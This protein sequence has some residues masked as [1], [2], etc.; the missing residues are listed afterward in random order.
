MREK[1]KYCRGKKENLNENK[2]IRF[3]KKNTKMWWVKK[4]KEKSQYYDVNKE[5]IKKMKI[6]W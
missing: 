3:Q 1:V 2:Q 5:K 6:V 4:E